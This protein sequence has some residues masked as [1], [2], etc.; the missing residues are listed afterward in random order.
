MSKSLLKLKHLEI[1]DINSYTQELQDEFIQEDEEI[2]SVIYEP[3]S[4]N[5]Y[6]YMFITLLNNGC[7]LYLEYD[8]ISKALTKIIKNSVLSTI[9]SNP[10]ES[11]E[12]CFSCPLIIS[13]SMNEI[14]YITSKTINT[15]VIDLTEEDI[16]VN[17]SYCNDPILDI[18][19]NCNQSFF[20]VTTTKKLLIYKVIYDKY[21]QKQT[22]T[23]NSNLV[24]PSHEDDILDINSMLNSKLFIRFSNFNESIIFVTFISDKQLTDEYSTISLENDNKVDE[25]EYCFIYIIKYTLGKKEN[26]YNVV[27]VFKVNKNIVKVSFT[28]FNEKMFFLFEDGIICLVNNWFLNESDENAQL[29]DVDSAFKYPLNSAIKFCDI[30]I[31]S[32]SHFIL[33]R[34]SQN[35]YLVFDFTLNLYYIMNNSQITVKLNL[36][37]SLN[38]IDVSAFQLLTQKEQVFIKA[39]DIY[40]IYKAKSEEQSINDFNVDKFVYNAV[41]SSKMF[42]NGLFLFDKKIINGIF[43]NLTSKFVQGNI[44]ANS[45]VLLDEFQILKNHLRGQ[46]I[47]SSFKILNIIQN[48]NIWIQALFLIL[49]KLCQNSANILLIKKHSLANALD[50]L[51]EKKF[52]D[53]NKNLTLKNIKILCFTNLIYRC[54]SINQYEYAFLIADKLKQPFM[55]KIIIGHAKQNKYIGMAYLASNKLE[56]IL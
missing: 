25:N 2:V 1:I 15:K 5:P 30:F 46:N 21:E 22:L 35:E 42:N 47:D 54:I 13:T 32:S 16:L 10:I 37:S 33:V 8:T 50:Y 55:F 26:K 43:I 7:L 48:F 20:L 14:I 56:V 6:E 45:N 17:S 4:N 40:Q 3:N 49:N 52:E 19:F 11:C 51:N 29:F 41:S 12:L 27:K 9:V 31:F 44:K 28:Y 53:E 39:N 18:K 38:N 34:D 36:G 23:V 24:I